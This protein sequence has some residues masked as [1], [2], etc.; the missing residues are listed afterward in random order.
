MHWISRHRI[1]NIQYSISTLSG[2]IVV[3]Y[4]D[5]KHAAVNIT[6]LKALNNMTLS[7]S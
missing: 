2:F 6:G 3:V 7:F 1:S 5:I 4:S